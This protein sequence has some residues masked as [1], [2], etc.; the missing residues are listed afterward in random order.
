MTAKTLLIFCDGTGMDG[1]LSQFNPIAQAIGGEVETVFENS[2]VGGG[3]NPQLPTNVVRLSRS[4]KSHTADGRRQIVFYQSGVGSEANFKGDPVRGTTVLQALGTAVASKIRDAYA[5]IAQNYQEGD[6]ICI[7]GWP[8]RGA[9]TARKLAGLIDLI[10]LLTRD[11]L[12]KFFL[13]WRQLVDKET[14]TIPDGTRR[15]KIKC[16]GVWD[17]VGSVYNTIDALEIKDTSLPK[18]VEIALHAVSLQENRQKFLP[19][20]WTVPQGGLAHNQVLKQF[21]F[22]GAHSDVGGGYLRREL[23]DIA[24]FWM[25]GEITSFIELDLVYLRSTRQPNPEPWGTSQPHNAYIDSSYAERMAVGH[26]TRL[27]SGQITRTPT[28]HQSLNFSPQALKSPDYMT[29]TSLIQQSF[30]PTF[31][32]NYPGLNFFEAFCM[33]NWNK[34]PVLGDPEPPIFE[35][36]GDIIRSPVYWVRGLIILFFSHSWDVDTSHVRLLV[37]GA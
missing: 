30:G 16:V 34:E 27:E 32:P 6:E 23:Q 14:P 35:N 20:L 25:A 17:T 9:Y 13:I 28:F 5:F 37:S 3:E 24:L 29:T 18:S 22:P 15:P 7:F 33:A 2:A 12:G 11:N 10:G 26:E 19:T 8:F 31:G 1:S 4:V 21:W 36:P